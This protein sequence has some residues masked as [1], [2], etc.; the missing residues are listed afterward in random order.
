[1]TSDFFNNFK[2][3]VQFRRIL[4]FFGYQ[5][6][7]HNITKFFL[8]FFQIKRGFLNKCFKTLDC[9]FII[10]T[11]FCCAAHHNKSGKC[12]KCVIHVFFQ[13]FLCLIQKLPQTVDSFTEFSAALAV[14]GVCR[15]KLVIPNTCIVSIPKCSHCFIVIA[16]VKIGNCQFLFII[17]FIRKPFCQLFHCFYSFSQISAPIL[18]SVQI[19]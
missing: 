19:K 12:I 17:C 7:A 9:F 5:D 4:S 16:S 13:I 11:A 14:Y 3:S 6:C 2:N 10:C 1:M 8:I 15:K 18:A